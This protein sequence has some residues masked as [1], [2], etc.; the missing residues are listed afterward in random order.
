M[1]N[2]KYNVSQ[3]QVTQADKDAVN[4]VME[5]GMISSAGPQVK[6]FAQEFAYAHGA[7]YGVVCNSGTNALY[8][9][10]K[11]MGVGPGWT[12]AVPEFTMIATAYAVSYTG[13]DLVFVDCNEDLNWDME[14]VPWETADAF[15]PVHIYGRPA[16]IPLTGTVI[17]D[18]AEAHGTPLTGDVACF[19]L[20]ANKIITTGEGGVIITNDK[21]IADEAYHLANM[22]FD[23]NHTFLHHKIA[24]NHRMTNL[25]AALGLSQLSR[26]DEIL[27]KR[28]KIEE[29]YDARL[30]DRIKMPA[31]DVVWYYDILLENQDERDRLVE[32]LKKGGI[33]TRLFFKPMSMQ[34]PY[35]RP[36]THLKAYDYSLR[37]IYLPTYTDLEEKDV[38]Y[39][40]EKVN[41]IIE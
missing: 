20:F 30:P 15:L 10:L 1:A 11:A 31:R 5:A 36:Y 2:W 17:E 3:P 26:M 22:A 13:A 28:K 38:D 12:V 19:S 35:L 24:H 39:I 41:A 34:K 33:E 32:G 7:K 9:A 27:A 23:E 16:T 21:D 4:T 25:Q 14:K 37:G 40:C 6:E 8:L 29:W 18:S